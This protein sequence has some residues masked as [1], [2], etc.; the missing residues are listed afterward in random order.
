MLTDIQYGRYSSIGYVDA[1]FLKLAL[2]EQITP[3]LDKDT[4]DIFVCWLFEYL[5][6]Q[7]RRNKIVCVLF[8]VYNKFSSSTNVLLKRL[9]LVI[10][11]FSV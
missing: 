1:R 5:R 11:F 9:C 3:I 2:Q 8:L 4:S 6:Q 7:N 10:I